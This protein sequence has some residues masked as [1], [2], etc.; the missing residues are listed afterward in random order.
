MS[1]KE[2]QPK[3][4]QPKEEERKEEQPVVQEMVRE[5]QAVKKCCSVMKEDVHIAGKCCAYTWCCTLNGIEGCC[6]ALSKCCLFMSELAMGCNK[7]LEQI[8]CDKH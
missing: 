1:S 4:E 8:D 2:E 5:E 6:L 3:E 7:C